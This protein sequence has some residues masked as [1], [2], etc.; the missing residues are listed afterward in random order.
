MDIAAEGD[1]ARARQA[2]RDLCRALGASAVGVQRIVTVVSELTRNMVLYAGGGCL[3]VEPCPK[4]RS[5]VTIVASDGG[6]GIADLTAILGGRYRSRT[7]AG[8]GLLGSKR[9]SGAFDVATGPAGTTVTAEV[10][11]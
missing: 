6:P 4:G 5:R 1:I 8:L 10:D 7:G 11:C 3:S 2:T 9:L